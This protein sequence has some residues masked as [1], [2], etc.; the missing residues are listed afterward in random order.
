MEMAFHFLPTA[1]LM[2]DTLL[3]S[4]PWETDALSALTV[5]SMVGS[6]YWIWVER[7]FSYNNFYPYPLLDMMTRE[8]RLLLFG[9]ATLLCWSSFLIVRGTYHMLNG[10]IERSV[11]NGTKYK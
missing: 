2:L 6:G 10:K 7:C 1:F 3:F 4:P 9:F 5:F 11:G 8:Q